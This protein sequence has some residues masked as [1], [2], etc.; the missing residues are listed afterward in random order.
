V[1]Y[2][3]EINQNSSESRSRKMAS[4]QRT[5]KPPTINGDSEGDLLIIGWGS[6]LGAIQEAVR[7]AR[8]EGLKV[9]SIHL[10]ILF[11]IVPGLVEIFARFKK[12]ITVEINYSDNPDH[13]M[14]TQE[15]RRYAQL[16]W[17]LRANTRWDIDCYS[18]VHGQPMSP[19]NIYNRIKKEL[20]EKKQ[21]KAIS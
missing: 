15:N 18:N 9:S 7:K 2:Q 4:F 14:I 6:T 12:V 21:I 3:P 10:T 13:P 8:N 17:Y 16:A 1:A 19:D 5:L 20:S 11:P